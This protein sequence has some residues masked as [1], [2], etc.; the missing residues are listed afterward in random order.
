MGVVDGEGR[1][2][3]S[4]S[5]RKWRGK[6]ERAASDTLRSTDL[7]RSMEARL[8]MFSAK[9]VVFSIS[10]AV[11]QRERLE[12]CSGMRQASSWAI[13]PPRERPAMW[14]VREGF[15]MVVVLVE[16]GGC[17]SVEREG[18]GDER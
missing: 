11:Q 10:A 9:V 6:M 18:E 7:G 15:F 2:T 8:A 16:E 14:M 1:R 17:C 4:A 5:A 13:M 12:M 3:L